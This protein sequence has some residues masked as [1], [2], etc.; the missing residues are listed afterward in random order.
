MATAEE[1]GQKNKYLT[2][3]LADEY[4][5]MEISYVTEIIGIQKITEVPRMPPYIKGVINLR[6]QVIPVMDVRLRF[7]LPERAYNDR[8]CIIVVST[9]LIVVG[10]AV[11][12]VSE[13]LVIPDERIEKVNRADQGVASRCI[14]GMAKLES[15]VKILLDLK[16]LVFAGEEDRLGGQLVQEALEE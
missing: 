3:L 4:Y 9:G 8:T 2:F 14:R 5:G 7:D 13:V 11:D 6:G 15:G 10:L 12:E 1:D 16:E